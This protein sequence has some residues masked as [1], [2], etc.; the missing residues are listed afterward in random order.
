MDIFTP[1][2]RSSVMR[3]IKSKGTK[4]ELRLMKALRSRGV[5][6]SKHVKS[7]PGTP[8]IVVRKNKVAIQVRGCFWHGHTCRDGHRPKS[9][10]SYWNPKL[11]NNK[12]RDRRKDE[13]LRGMGWHV[14]TIWE[15]RLSGKKKLEA[16][17][18]RAINFINKHAK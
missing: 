4:P 16:Q 2:K 10:K 1:E 3:T 12:R 13:A 6:F 17:A 9:R 5:R 14:M 18:Q 8:D 11:A 7:L 15:C